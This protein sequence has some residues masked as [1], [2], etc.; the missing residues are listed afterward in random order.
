MPEKEEGRVR[1][2]QAAREGGGEG[3]TDVDICRLVEFFNFRLGLVSDK[4]ELSL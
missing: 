4:G 1:S 3:L 2:G